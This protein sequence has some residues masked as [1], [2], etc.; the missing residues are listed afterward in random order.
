MYFFKTKEV[1]LPDKYTLWRESAEALKISPRAKLRLEWMVFYETIAKKDA[2]YTAEYFSISRK[3]FH[4]WYKR[5]KEAKGNPKS[6]EELSRAPTHKRN[7]EVTLEEEYN[8]IHLRKKHIKYGKAKLKVLYKGEYG[9][10][11]STWKIERVVRRH[12]LYPDK[13]RHAKIQKKRSKKAKNPRKRIQQLE[14]DLTTFGHLWHIDCIVLNWYGTRRVL[15]TAVENLTRLGYAR[16]YNSNTSKEAT[17]F[18][19]R[20]MYLVEGKVEIM[21]SDNGSEFE[22]EFRRACLILGIEQV[23]SRPHTPKDNPMV[24]RFNWTVQDE[25]LSL[26][27]KGLDNMQEAN[28]ELSLWLTEYNNVR[29]HESL[30][31]LTPLDYAQREFF[32]KDKVLPMW[33]ARTDTGCN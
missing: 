12:K 30:A 24:E 1:S 22:G 23:Y 9:E 18:L 6:L 10:D 21:H 16:V 7:W 13:A 29:P 14:K 31:Y 17:D 15:V 26:S 3:T 5:F 27:D 28:E 25:W 8:I 11:I 4:K 2:S 32:S 19:K 20:L 33:S